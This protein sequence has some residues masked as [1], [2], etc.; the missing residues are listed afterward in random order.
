MPKLVSLLGCDRETLEHVLKA[1]GWSRIAVSGAEPPT[2]VWRTRESRRT[3][4]AGKTTQDMPNASPFAELKHMLSA[5]NATSSPRRRSSQFHPR[6]SRAR[7]K[8]PT[9]A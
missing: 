7:L 4:R 9:G 6:H 1:L 5:G 8:E 3:Q 2:T